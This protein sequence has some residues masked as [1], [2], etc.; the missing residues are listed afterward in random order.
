M[1]DRLVGAVRKAGDHITT[2]SA[3]ATVG[4]P[5]SPAGK[6]VGSGTHTF[7]SSI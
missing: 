3:T 5:G 2:G 7:A 1:L 6:T 4:L